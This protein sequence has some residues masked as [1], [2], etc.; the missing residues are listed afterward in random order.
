MK[1]REDIEEITGDEI[2]KA[3]EK[4]LKVIQ[5]TKAELKVF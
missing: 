2:D 4:P 1:N 5:E 3:I